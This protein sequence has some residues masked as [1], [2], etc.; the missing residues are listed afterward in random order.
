MG[1]R[2]ELLKAKGAPATLDRV[3]STKDRVDCLFRRCAFLKLQQAGFHCFQPFQALFEKDLAELCH[4]D[5]HCA[6]PKTFLIV[7]SSWSGLKGLTSQPVAP[8]ALPSCFFS[9]ADSVVSM[10]MGVNL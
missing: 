8:A 1:E 7:A 2:G 10:S 5:R 6:Y 9:G 4:V 3:S